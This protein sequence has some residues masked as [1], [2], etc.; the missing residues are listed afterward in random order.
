ME[1]Q[2]EFQENFQIAFNESLEKLGPFEDNPHLAVAVSGGS[3][4]MS[5][6]LLAKTWVHQYVSKGFQDADTGILKDEGNRGTLTALIVD[7][8]LR[9]EST[10]EAQ[11]VRMLLV[12]PGF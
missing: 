12:S 1:F 9:G 5:L 2:G 8:G 10:A 3:D 7:H 6:A 11:Q 4:S